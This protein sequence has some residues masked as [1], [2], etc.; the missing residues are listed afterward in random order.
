M[1][2][3]KIF[4]MTTA[5]EEAIS[6][7]LTKVNV[8]QD[9]FLISDGMLGI[10][11][12]DKD[13]FGMED[14]QLA[15]AISGEL[16][17]SQKQYV[18][19]EGLCRAYGD[20]VSLFTTKREVK[21]TLAKE[22]E[23]KLTAYDETWDKELEQKYLDMKSKIGELEMKHKKAPKPQKEAILKELYEANKTFKELSDS[24]DEYKAK[25]EEGKK[26]LD[27]EMSEAK[28]ALVNFNGKIK[29]NKG[30]LEAAEE[31]RE[32]AKVFIASSK[33]LIADIQS[34]SIAKEIEAI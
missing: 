32:H 19:Q 13:E 18:L 1:T 28:V 10:L 30:L 4:E 33:K 20:M 22:L 16:T 2:K 24:F 15:V 9:G 21:V 23:E 25:F 31:D 3:V 26:T 12:K 14:Q 11:Y 17:K 34:G 29:E 6:E 8:T 5:N 27:S 7:F